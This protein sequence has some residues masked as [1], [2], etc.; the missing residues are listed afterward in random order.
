[1]IWNLKLNLTFSDG[2]IILLGLVARMGV[3]GGTRMSSFLTGLSFRTAVA[4]LSSAGT[5]LTIG[6]S[7]A[8]CS[9]LLGSGVRRTRFLLIVVVDF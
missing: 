2:F 4:A 7:R 1:M 3:T 9:C 5:W 6:V 8:C